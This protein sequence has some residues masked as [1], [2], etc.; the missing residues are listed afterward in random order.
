MIF[1][2]KG[3]VFQVFLIVLAI[4]YAYPV[5][6]DKSIGTFSAQQSCPAYVSKNKLTNPDKARILAGKEYDAIEV[7]KP[8]HPGWYRVIVPTANP[9]ERWV[10]AECGQ[11]R[12]TEAEP[13]HNNSCSTAGQADSYVLA[14]SWQPAFCEIKPQK[15][16][17]QITD[18]TAYQAKHFTLHGLWPNK[19]NCG[20]HYAFCGEVKG[21]K[22]DFCDYPEIELDPASQAALA[23]VMPSVS[24]GS[25]L[26]RH[27]WHKHG[28]CQASWA[29][30]GFFEVS[31]SLV[32]Q[33]ND[34]GMADFMSQRIGRQVRTRD[35]LDKVATVLGPA[36][37]DRIK[38]NCNQGMLVE[39][40][41]SLSA[42]LTPESGLDQLIMNA[43]AQSDSNCGATFRV[44]PIG[45]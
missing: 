24:A 31:V 39:V 36:A 14:L 12:M 33:F 21:Q 42:E 4:S 34:S 20:T 41:L 23:E 45:R 13:E 30:Q 28:T 3:A 43:P 29:V 10:N 25:C 27:E 37:R 8:D 35:F 32:R 5:W 11:A 38:L 19:K 2:R 18:P 16:E 44:D 17:C 22:Q 6:A 40:Q 15:P 1:L 9:R 7:N 26:E